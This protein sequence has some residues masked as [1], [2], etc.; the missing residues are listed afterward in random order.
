MSMYIYCRSRKRILRLTGLDVSEEKEGLAITLSG[1]GSVFLYSKADHEAASFTVLNFHADNIDEAVDE[2]N[3]R[4]IS[5]ESYEGEIKT[6]GKGIFRGAE[7][8]IGPN[9]AWF[10]DPAGNIL[11][12]VEAKK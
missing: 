12:V 7:K 10:K 3:G 4:G 8:N 5:F 11:S 6:D 9:I 2:L 1:G